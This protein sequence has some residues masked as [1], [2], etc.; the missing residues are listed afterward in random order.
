[1]LWKKV[2]FWLT[3]PL[4]KAVWNKIVAAAEWPSICVRNKTERK[5]KGKKVGRIEGRKKGRLTVIEMVCRRAYTFN[6][7][8]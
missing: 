3:R 8:N 2:C 1:M 7:I 6:H 5:P 4:A